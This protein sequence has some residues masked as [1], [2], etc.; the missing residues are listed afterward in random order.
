MTRATYSGAQTV[1]NFELDTVGFADTGRKFLKWLQTG[2][3]RIAD[4]VGSKY[5]E[6][7]PAKV[8]HCSISYTCISMV[9]IV[10]LEISV[11]SKHS[12]T[13]TTYMPSPFCIE[14]QTQTSVCI[15]FCAR[16]LRV[17]VVITLLT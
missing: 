15:V 3:I 6:T 2:Q 17:C 5:T 8:L 9:S 16:N 12:E 1:L 4:S 13:G 11:G 10:F 14:F 7:Q